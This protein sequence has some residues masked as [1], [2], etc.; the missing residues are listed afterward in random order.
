MK[1]LYY[2]F[3]VAHHVGNKTDISHPNCIYRFFLHTTLRQICRGDYGQQGG[4]LLPG[5]PS[6]NSVSVPEWS[7]RGTVDVKRVFLAHLST[8]NEPASIEC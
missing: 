8:S 1:I 7:M 6:E 2:K 4:R 5:F 3:G